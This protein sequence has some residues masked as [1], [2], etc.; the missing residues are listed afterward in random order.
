M[1][2]PYADIVAR[3]DLSLRMLDTSQVYVEAQSSK[4]LTGAVVAE[5]LLP[6]YAHKSSPTSRS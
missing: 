5:N 4:N 1:P 2:E 6:T 3:L